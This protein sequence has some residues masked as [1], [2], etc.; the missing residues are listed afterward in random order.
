MLSNGCD[1]L[2]D[3]P[4]GL[5]PVRTTHAAQPGSF[6]ARVLLDRCQLIGGNVQPVLAGVCND[7]I[8]TLNAGNRPSNEPLKLA[9]AMSVVDYVVTRGEVP[10]SDFGVTRTRGGA[11]VCSTSP[12]NGLLPQHRNVGSSKDEPMMNP[13]ADESILTPGNTF[14]LWECE[15]ILTKLP[16]NAGCSGRP[17]HRKEHLHPLGH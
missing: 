8:I 10:E 13:V 5:C 6:S 1:S 9:D 7:Q 3:L 2:T 11:A 15:S 16:S 12:S 17:I 14:L 4:P